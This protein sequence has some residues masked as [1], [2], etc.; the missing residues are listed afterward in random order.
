MKV[1][2]LMIDTAK[3]RVYSTEI[4]DLVMK[5]DDM[6]ETLV[7]STQ[8]A[9]VLGV[10]DDTLRGYTRLVKNPLKFTTEPWGLRKRMLY[11]REDVE[12]F[13]KQHGLRVDW[14]K[15]DK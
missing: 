7:S 8:A 3:E 12:A 5:G 6:K 2:K 15:A 13:A 10:N 4:T 14:E 11:R 1:P 9:A